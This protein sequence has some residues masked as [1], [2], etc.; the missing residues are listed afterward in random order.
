MTN[1]YTPLQQAAARELLNRKAARQNPLHYAALIDVPG[2]PIDESP[3]PENEPFSPIETGLADHHKLLLRA[4]EEIANTPY[5]RLMVF[6]PPGSAKS[7]YASVVF[8]SW[9]LGANPGSKIILTSYGDIL[10]RRMGR[11]TR[12]IIRQPRYAALFGAEVTK[13]SSAV[14]QFALTNG[15]EYMA[16]G[17]LSGITGNRANGVII[18]DPIK[19]REAAESPTIRNKTYDAYLDDVLTRLIPGGW[20]VLIQTRWHEDDLAGHLLPEGWKGESGK[21]RCRDG[22]T[23]NVICLQAKCETD[24]DPLGRKRGEYIWPEWFDKNHWS[25][26]EEQPRTWASLFQQ[27]PS[28]AEGGLFKP[29]QI[30]TVDAIPAGKITWVRGW[31]FAATSTGDYTAGVKLGRLEDGRLIIADVQRMRCGPDERD[32]AIRNTAGAD[33]R[34]TLIS[35]PQDPGQAGKTQALYMTRSLFGY[36]VKSSPESGSKETRAEPVAAQVN[37]GNVM[38]LRGGWNR[39]FIEELRTF[40]N[41]ANDDQVDALSRAF[42]ELIETRRKLNIR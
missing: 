4:L 7:T 6:M 29:A 27:L 10:P 24:N 41:G 25:Q 36:R 1:S 2:R 9:Y 23:W 22:M 5:G 42:A 40:P 21:I 38:M 32:S 30:D 33:G 14:Q 15:S 34:Q 8:P 18:D 13:D 12:Q 11:R 28:P 26:F 31:D 37:V 20:V 17:I 16:A 39:D 19:G 3:D 35:I